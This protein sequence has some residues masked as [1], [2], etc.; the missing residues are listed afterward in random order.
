[1][2]SGISE[3]LLKHMIMQGVSSSLFLLVF[4]NVVFSD[5]VR[6]ENELNDAEVDKMKQCF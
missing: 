1:M 4:F 6:M 5:M 2:I 3:Q